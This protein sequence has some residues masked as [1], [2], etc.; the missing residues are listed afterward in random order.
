MIHQIISDEKGRLHQFNTPA[1]NRRL[2]QKIFVDGRRR[3]HRADSVDHCRS[4][5]LLPVENVVLKN[6]AEVRKNLLQ[7]FVRLRFRRI[8]R[9]KIVDERLVMRIENR[10]TRRRVH[11]E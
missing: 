2:F 7:V 3:T 6:R 1:E 9:E 5:D 10:Q 4:S 11:R 8:R